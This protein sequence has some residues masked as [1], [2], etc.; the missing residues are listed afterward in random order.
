MD[1]RTNTFIPIN[2]PLSTSSMKSY[3]DAKVSEDLLNE[4]IDQL[5]NYM[6][7]EKL[8]TAEM[9]RELSN[10]KPFTINDVCDSIKQSATNG[11]KFAK[12]FDISF[13]PELL[14]QILDLGYEISS[15]KDQFGQLVTKITW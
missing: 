10:Q 12:F 13:T 5:K 11:S 9:A 4:K 7:N 15:N 2:P 3:I 8:L 6:E 1:K 14:K